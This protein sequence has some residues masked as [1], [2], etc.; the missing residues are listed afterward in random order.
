MAG[1]PFVGAA[2]QLLDRIIKAMGLEREEVYICNVVKCRPP[3]NRAP[4]PS[5]RNICGA[6]LKR[7]LSVIQPEIIVALG[8]VAA[9][10]LLDSEASLG[11]MRGRFH[12]MNG[13]RVMPTYHPAY[14]LRNPSAKRDVWH[15]VQQVMAVLGLGGARGKRDERKG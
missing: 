8:S 13:I 2:G 12:D 7:Q 1:R 14:L 6:F 11:S 5:E 9:S 10:Y 4:E 3:N 15:D